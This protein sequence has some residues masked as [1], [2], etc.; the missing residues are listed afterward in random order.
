MYTP[1]QPSS[2]SSRDQSSV[3]PNTGIHVVIQPSQSSYFAGEPFTCTVT[4]TNTR[5][6]IPLQPVRSLSASFTPR[7]KRAAHS[8]SSAPLARPPTS[9]GTP[10]TAQPFLTQQSRE[11]DRGD[12][13]RRRG[14]IGKPASV[15]TAV[16]EQKRRT[17][18]RSLSVD[19][20][21]QDL[22]KRLDDTDLLRP[23]TLLRSQSEHPLPSS[24]RISSPLATRE[25]GSALPPSHPHARKPSVVSDDVAS[26]TLSLPNQAPQSTPNTAS[27]PSFQLSLDPITESNPNSSTS[28]MPEHVVSE[29]II[30]PPPPP[31]PQ[32]N[33][34]GHQRRPSHL[35]LG[36]PLAVPGAM[37][38]NPRIKSVGAQP[39]YTAFST[40][41]P[42]PS[43][44]L[45]LYAYAQLTGTLSIDP[46]LVPSSSEL[47]D[48]R[49]ALRKKAAVGG[50]SLDIGSGTQLPR[51]SSSGSIF[52][53][54]SSSASTNNTPYHS[55]LPDDTDESLPTLETQPSML[56]IDLTLA[57]GESRS[58]SYTLDLPA[59][60]PPT[61]KGR[62]LRLSYQ[63][64][65]GTCRAATPFT[66]ALS[67]WTLNSSPLN[68]PALTAD[69][70]RRR[71]RVMRVPIRVYNHVAIGRVPRPYDLMWP[72][73][74]RREKAATAGSIDEMKGDKGAVKPA[75]PTGSLLS[76]QAYAQRLLAGEVELEL[77]NHTGETGEGG[78]LSGC[79]EAVEI[80]T[81]NPKKVSYDVSKDGEKVAELTFVKSAYRL[82]ETVLGVVELNEGHCRSKVL[83]LS[84]ILEAHENLPWPGEPVR[85]VHAEHHS[86]L[87]SDMRRVSFALDIPSDASPAFE[88]TQGPGGQVGGLEWKVRLSLLVS[89]ATS[90]GNA[91]GK[92]REVEV[93]GL[94]RDGPT[95]E[96]GTS[97]RAS[98]SLV[99]MERVRAPISERPPLLKTSSSWTA[100]FSPFARG[101]YHDADEEESDDDDDDGEWMEMNAETVECMVP[102]RVFAGNTAFRAMEVMFDV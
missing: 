33:R 63:L 83:K 35:G 19:F 72:I 100:I 60:L 41:F 98:E 7:H 27:T 73:A 79:R 45:L 30:Q 23:G 1:R 59:N 96:W 6:A 97:W 43:T 8:V 31:Q 53:F 77:E 70:E 29:D 14:L 52:G 64:V 84:A 58:Y 20:S 13:A 51:V 37:P 11:E 17:P 36:L 76:V 50:G 62:A 94:V 71:S 15:A 68:S 48:L 95:G 92:G 26:Q 55:G 10:K 69:N 91:K 18:T 54:F 75:R 66:S 57:A 80:T 93:R 28:T 101:T 88:V 25:H 87:V 78:S 39:P 47:V 2:S 38:S 32:S 40:T 21:P 3:D 99:P 102:I 5:S 56:A 65:V 4:F 24:P 85:R 81:R 89:V 82:G 46:V 61:F 90:P 12:I 74:R 9:P 16:L 86:S 34:T 49:D 42:Q 22:A 67:S 44:E